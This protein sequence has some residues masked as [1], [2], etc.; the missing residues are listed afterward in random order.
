[1]KSVFHTGVSEITQLAWVI[2][3]FFLYLTLLQ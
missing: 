1:M 2:S 3:L